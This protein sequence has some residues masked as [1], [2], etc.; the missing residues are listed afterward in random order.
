MVA[1]CDNIIQGIDAHNDITNQDVEELIW[2][3]TQ[4]T[5]SQH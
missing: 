3:F 5:R 4:L 2:A 1:E